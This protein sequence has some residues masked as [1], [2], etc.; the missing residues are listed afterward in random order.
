MRGHVGGRGCVWVLNKDELKEEFLKIGCMLYIFANIKFMS[1]IKIHRY[2]YRLL[3][4][5]VNYVT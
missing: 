1:S 4:N 2:V 5:L 3:V